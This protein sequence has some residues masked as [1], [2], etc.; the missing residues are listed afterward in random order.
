MRTKERITAIRLIN[1]IEKHP[2]FAKKVGISFSNSKTKDI[3]KK[4]GCECS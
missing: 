2:E 3:K 4:E 1:K